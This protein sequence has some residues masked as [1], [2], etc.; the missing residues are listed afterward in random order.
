VLKF[1]DSSDPPDSAQMAERVLVSDPAAEDQFARTFG[2]RIYAMALVRTGDPDAARD[3]SQSALIEALQALRKG[4]LRD[5]Q[6]LPAFVCGTA[7][8]VINYYLRARSRAPRSEPLG[9]DIPAGD[10]VPDLERAE[11]LALVR[12][13]L[14][15]LEPDDRRILMMTLV[16]GLKPAEIAAR[17]GLS[18]EVVRQRKSRAVKRVIDA[19]R[20]LLRS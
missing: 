8:N 14:E 16:D 11:R 3:L 5:P 2:P 19:V 13:A 4:R 7:R 12:R 10:Q 6:K 17:L 15:R 1:K 20:S 9:S 18:S